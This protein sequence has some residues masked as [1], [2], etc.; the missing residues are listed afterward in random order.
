M[1]VYLG[2]VVTHFGMLQNLTGCP[3]VLLPHDWQER[4]QLQVM[5]LALGPVNVFEVTVLLY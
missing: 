4:G 2:T 1:Y 3:P 5:K